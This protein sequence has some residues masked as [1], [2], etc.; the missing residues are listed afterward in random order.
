MT[1]LPVMGTA[2]I[3]ANKLDSSNCIKGAVLTIASKAAGRITTSFTRRVSAA[4][5]RFTMIDC[6]HAKSP[7]IDEIV[8][9]SGLGRMPAETIE[10]AIVRYDERTPNPP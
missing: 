6:V 4:D 7:F 1:L 3:N 5:R 2:L 10:A 8:A 9:R